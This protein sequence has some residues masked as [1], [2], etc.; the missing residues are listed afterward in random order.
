MRDNVKH[1]SIEFGGN[2]RLDISLYIGN[3][4]SRIS[5]EVWTKGVH[6]TNITSQY[7]Y[8]NFEKIMPRKL[9]E[10]IARYQINKQAE[11]LTGKKFF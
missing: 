4:I 5:M 9:G 7:T 2:K 10:K 11:R 3:F 8:L 6:H 1:Y